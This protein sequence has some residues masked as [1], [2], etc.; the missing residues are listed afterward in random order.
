MAARRDGSGDA[1]M[2]VDLGAENGD[3]VTLGE[4]R[5]PEYPLCRFSC[6]AK[7]A[8][9]AF[10]RSLAGVLRTRCGA[11]PG[12]ATGGQQAGG[13]TAARRQA[14]SLAALTATHCR[15]L[16]GG[17]SAAARGGGLDTPGPEDRPTPPRPP[18]RS[19]RTQDPAP[20]RGVGPHPRPG[21]PR[22]LDHTQDQAPPGGGLRQWG[23]T[24]AASEPACRRAH[25]APVR[26]SP[27]RAPPRAPPEPRR[28]VSGETGKTGKPPPRC[29]SASPTPRGPPL[30]RAL[31]R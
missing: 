5:A 25:A 14:V 2:D 28:R 18:T 11:V 9:Q 27:T 23:A 16:G 31:R 29:A 22:G 12:W 26:R 1:P 21:T 10:A 8:Q 24:R 4:E 20:R 6:G 13:C 7:A 3:R 30:R 19:D 15:S 17:G